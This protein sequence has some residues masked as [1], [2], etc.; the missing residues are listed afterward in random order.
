MRKKRVYELARDLGVP[1]NA[2]LELSAEMDMPGLVA[3]S[4]LDDDAARSIVERWAQSLDSGEVAEMD[5]SELLE[6]FG[7]AWGDVVASQDVE[8]QR[9]YQFADE[10]GTSSADILRICASLELGVASP[11]SNLTHEQ[12]R[13]VRTALESEDRSGSRV[14]E[15]GM[16]PVSQ[17]V[18][19]PAPDDET[20]RD[21]VADSLTP[22]FEGPD[23]QLAN[24]QP[25]DPEAPRELAPLPPDPELVVTRVIRPTVV[26][27]RQEPVAR[28]TGLATMI[29]RLPM[30]VI[31][32][33]AAFLPFQFTFGSSRRPLQ[34]APSDFLLAGAILMLAPQLRFRKRVWT[35][36]HFAF[37]ATFA[38]SILAG[39]ALSRYS[40]A[41]KMVGM[42]VLL[43][44]Y[45]VI[46]TF[47]TKWSEVRRIMRAFVVSV[48]VVN[49]ITS[50]AKVLG[51]TLPYTKCHSP[52]C[53]RLTG[54]FP[55]ANLYGSLL[56]V[57]IA[58]LLGTM[59]TDAQLFSRLRTT[60]VVFVSLGSGLFLTLSR[61]S[62][63]GMALVLGAL[64]VLRPGHA[65]RIVLFGGAVVGSLLTFVLAER[66]DFLLSVANRRFSIDS[67][68]DIIDDALNAFGENPFFGIGLGNFAERHNVIVH[69][70]VLW[71]A[72]ELGM[73]GLVLLA[74][75]M[76]FVTRQLWFLYRSTTGPRQA[77]VTALALAHL[78]M[79][80]F[81][82]GVEALYQRH[83]WLALSL[84]SV[85]YAMVHEAVES[86]LTEPSRGPATVVVERVPA[87]L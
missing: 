25:S 85:L 31:L 43:A 65:T 6:R 64:V 47:V 74:G 37:P 77:M 27:A 44:A 7:I 73:V 10:T 26:I 58:L 61:S 69:N 50:V 84:I 16:A 75:L 66:S 87:G 56:V 46:T 40:L 39:G 78:A 23:P 59:G 81:S 71:L 18:G 83:W 86:D 51:V 11:L 29:D 32:A 14:S 49:T 19:E 53:V 13:L 54:Y 2:I 41:N 30:L 12:Q 21:G 55:D 70:T 24:H 1:T 36:W 79:L 34:L 20:L 42:L 33:W 45:T 3:V 9:V 15:S 48:F 76:W 35:F 17:Q 28:Q 68:L 22:D 57:A 5:K 38:I 52:S 82:I 63:I 62:W 80:G 8:S 4:G 67:R 72:A 60:I